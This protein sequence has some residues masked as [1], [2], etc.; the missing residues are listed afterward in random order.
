MAASTA[1][2][3]G[4][5]NARE[6]SQDRGPTAKYKKPLSDKSAPSIFTSH[7]G[8]ANLKSVGTPSPLTI[9]INPDRISSRTFSDTATDISYVIV[10]LNAACTD[11]DRRRKKLGR[12][13]RVCAGSIYQHFLQNYHPKE[14]AVFLAWAESAGIDVASLAPS[15]SAINTTSLESSCALTTFHASAIHPLPATDLLPATSH[16]PDTARPP[17]LTAVT[18]LLDQLEVYK[19]KLATA[20][21]N[22]IQS[23]QRAL[24]M[25]EERNC[26]KDVQAS[27]E[28]KL[29]RVRS[30]LDRT[31]TEEQTRIK[32]QMHAEFQWP[33]LELQK[34]REE[35]ERSRAELQKSHAALEAEKTACRSAR[36]SLNALKRRHL[37]HQAV[38]Q[39]TTSSDAAALVA[40]A[41][42]AAS[43]KAAP[44]AGQTPDN[45]K[46]KKNSTK[47][48]LE[49]DL[50]AALEV[51][52]DVMAERDLLKATL[53]AELASR[54]V[55]S[56]TPL[57][58]TAGTPAAHSS[59]ARPA[60]TEQ[61]DDHAS[62]LVKSREATRVARQG[63][64]EL[65]AALEE[66][67][68][69][70]AAQVK[71]LQDHLQE[72]EATSTHASFQ[73]DDPRASLREADRTQ[74]V[75][76][77]HLQRRIREA[78][79]AY[80]NVLT[81][82]QGLGQKLERVV[83][84]LNSDRNALVFTQ[85]ELST[86]LNAHRHS[87]ELL[88]LVK[89]T[90]AA[91]EARN[92]DLIA[93]QDRTLA[94][95]AKTTQENFVALRDREGV[96]SRLQE[97]LSTKSSQLQ[98]SLDV[99]DGLSQRLRSAEST[100]GDLNSQLRTMVVNHDAALAIVRQEAT[101]DEAKRHGE[102]AAA[103]HQAQEDL[104]AHASEA[105]EATQ[106]RDA[107]SRELKSA[108]INIIL[109]IE[110]KRRLTSSRDAAVSRAAQLE[111][112]I[113]CIRRF[114]Q[115][116]LHDVMQQRDD[117][118]NRMEVVGRDHD[119]LLAVLTATQEVLGHAQSEVEQLNQDVEQLSRE[120]FRSP[121]CDASIQTILDID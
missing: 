103:L 83:T 96:I 5:R 112:D 44:S 111:S 119:A 88:E 13:I 28:A 92:S 115:D 99:S 10:E 43:E 36:A 56:A 64:D 58:Q 4:K 69:T 11:L 100:V 19:A 85:Q 105:R 48:T 98:E 93:G 65:Q 49:C 91:L 53:A 20:Q 21:H 94:S 66:I 95:H 71:Q 3:L 26:A 12:V 32:E 78:E 107:F 104:V 101:S 110:E 14:N 46:S 109:M 47:A 31:R 55:S 27:L 80:A 117:A 54:P 87:L 51:L 37:E 52:R 1:S 40:A 50:G 76:V 35:L 81:E 72:A 16:P 70:H 102:I 15:T 114:T 74:S 23:S 24:D 79:N 77:E 68:R 7:T 82:N 41:Q 34:T 25:I 63:R 113:D 29:D 33:R 38:T 39:P 59:P 42:T 89:V 90:N 121:L 86:S 73:F 61:H 9:R 120:T 8:E 84:Q 22:F 97:E 116:Q 2:T 118:R 106:A 75:Q 57:E 30:D 67:E 6:R 17:S 45:T 108:E 60:G 18:P 62:A